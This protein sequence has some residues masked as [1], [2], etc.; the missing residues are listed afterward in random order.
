MLTLQVCI[1][2]LKNNFTI[3]YKIIW[4]LIVSWQIHKLIRSLIGIF[5]KLSNSLNNFSPFP[6]IYTRQ[7]HLSLD[8]S[9]PS[10]PDTSNDHY[11][12][13]QHVV[14]WRLITVNVKLSIIIH[15]NVGNSA[16]RRNGEI[17][18]NDVY[19]VVHF[20]ST[21]LLLLLD[22]ASR[23]GEIKQYNSEGDE[24]GFALVKWGRNWPV[25]S[26]RSCRMSVFQ[27]N[28]RRIKAAD[29]FSDNNGELLLTICQEMT[30]ITLM[31]GRDINL[32]RMSNLSFLL[33]WYSL[34]IIYLLIFY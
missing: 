9:D 6:M 21:G 15:I 5:V 18:V 32:K 29:S 31:N 7:N 13:Q 23:Q 3:D 20:C 28:D 8:L 25:V 27:K 14:L 34:L 12:F 4:F 22:P 17:F 33:M 19:S 11:M 30:W 16:N 24:N 10:S 1:R 26:F 2:F